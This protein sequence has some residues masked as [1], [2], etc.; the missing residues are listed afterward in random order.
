LNFDV[1]LEDVVVLGLKHL[2][3]VLHSLALGQLVQLLLHLVVAGIKQF[4]QLLVGTQ[5]GFELLVLLQQ[6]VGLVCC[7]LELLDQA[8][9][10]LA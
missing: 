7:L 3:G 9:A 1:I 6:F 8:E 4:V 2:H 10:I 5:H